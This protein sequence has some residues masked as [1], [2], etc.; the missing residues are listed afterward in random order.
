MSIPTEIERLKYF[1]SDSYMAVQEKGGAIPELNNIANLP[2]AIR[3]IPVGVQGDV[4]TIDL[5]ASDPNGG[6]IIGGGLA[7]SGMKI[8]VEAHPNNKWTFDGWKEN[9]AVVSE[10]EEYTFRVTGDRTLIAE[11]SEKA[12]RLPDGYTELAYLDTSYYSTSGVSI[13][14][15]TVTLT[16]TT[17]IE[18][19]FEYNGGC[20]GTLIDHPDINY[21]RST[22]MII[23]NTEGTQLKVNIKGSGNNILT[24][25]PFLNKKATF[26]IDIQNKAVSVDGVSQNFDISYNSPTYGILSIGASS[27]SSY[28]AP[29]KYYEMRVYQDSIL[30]YHLIPA[31]DSANN[32]GFYDVIN[33]VFRNVPNAGNSAWIAGPTV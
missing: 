5:Q 28:R 14:E 33:S 1:V 31:I 32:I 16:S 8:T 25:D 26:K 20:D 29:G 10:G 24:F 19:D 27:S 6:S 12:T 30:A 4:H 21:T 17:V 7:S 2:D 22:R 3:G 11:F 18:V 23:N 9:N 13:S 15:N